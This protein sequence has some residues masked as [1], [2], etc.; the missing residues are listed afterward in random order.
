MRSQGAHTLLLKRGQKK[1]KFMKA[2]RCASYPQGVKEGFHTLL[3]DTGRD[4]YT[5]LN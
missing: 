3:S 2:D 1:G 5:S 4:R